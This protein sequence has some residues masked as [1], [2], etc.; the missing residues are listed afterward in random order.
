M[1]PVQ[2]RIS[3]IMNLDLESSRVE[4]AKNMLMGNDDFCMAYIQAFRDG[5]LDKTNNQ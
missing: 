3:E 1:D 5:L 2:S 4:F